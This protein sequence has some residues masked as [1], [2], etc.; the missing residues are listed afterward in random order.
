MKLIVASCVLCVLGACVSTGDGGEKVATDADEAAQQYYE[1][2]ARYYRNGNYE[3]AR[4][5]LERALE[6]DPKMAIAHSTLAMTYIALENPRLAKEHY[7]QAIKAEP[8]N[9]DVR[10]AYA[11][12]LC[13]QRDYD[14][15]RD[16]FDRAIRVYD[17]DNAEVMLTNAGVCMSNKPD[18]VAAED[19]FRRALEFK[20]SYGEALLQLSALKHQT[21]DD[22]RA[23][24]FMQ[25]YMAGNSATA[26]VLLLAI[27]IETA[28]DD[29]R[30]ATDLIN[31]LLRDFPNSPESKYIERQQ[32]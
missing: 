23:R 30:A 21:G 19:Y 12:Y 28:L 22:L 5:R 32:D 11:V 2:G 17:N 9:F 27:Q 25:R 6:F 8:N 1:L 31:R 16:Q 4:D 29:D 15:A 7:E 10:N 14:D 18:Y 24:A 13:Q 20:S 26:G 3:Y